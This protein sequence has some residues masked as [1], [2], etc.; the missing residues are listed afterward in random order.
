MHNR[1]LLLIIYEEYLN[2]LFCLT[3]V[4]ELNADI[5]SHSIRDCLRL[6][7]Y[8]KLSR[9]SRPRPILLKLNRAVDATTTLA[10]RAL[11]PQG[12]TIKPDQTKEDRH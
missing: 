1:T 9:S 10:N 5:D 6:G 11:A 3:A 4:S 8:N 2:A 12:I 7:S